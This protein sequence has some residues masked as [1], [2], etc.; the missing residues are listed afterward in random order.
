MKGI[1]KSFSRVEKGINKVK[2]YN[3]VINLMRENN[4]I[5]LKSANLDQGSSAYVN[6]LES[7]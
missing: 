6:Y 1:D 7:K 5:D 3:N 2:E 4:Y